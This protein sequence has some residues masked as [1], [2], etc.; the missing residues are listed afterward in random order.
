MSRSTLSDILARYLAHDE[1]SPGLI[2]LLDDLEA[3]PVVPVE[4]IGRLVDG[5]HKTTISSVLSDALSPMQTGALREMAHGAR[6][7]EEVGERLRCSKGSAEEHLR[8]ARARLGAVSTSHAVGLALGMGA[9]EAP[10]RHTAEGR[11]IARSLLRPRKKERDILEG[12]ARGLT[13]DELASEIGIST[14]TIKDS[15]EDLLEMY[16][17]KNRTHLV[18]LAFA[19]GTLKFVSSRHPE[20]LAA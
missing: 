2:A 7:L 19:V 16:G 8:R 15:I 6:T 10:L 9:F 13:N 11:F 3:A 4:E 12:L 5:G 18:A 20:P 14:E 17:A 1:D